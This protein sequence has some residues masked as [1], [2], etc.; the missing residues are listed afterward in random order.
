VIEI[1]KNTNYDFLGRKLLFIGLS[2]FVLL[3]GLASIGWRAL[4]GDQNTH[5]FNFGI[6]FTGGTLVNAKFKEPPD[7]GRLR[8]A[9]EE[10]G[11]DSSKITLQ[12]INEQIGRE[13]KN[14]VFIRI[15]N[16]ETAAGATSNTDLGK[17][18]ILAAL[19]TL[20]D[21]VATQGKINLNLIGRDE[22]K[23][24]FSRLDPLGIR[25]SDRSLPDDSSYG[26]IAVRI[27][28]YREQRGG[29]IGSLDEIKN[30]GGIES[31]L[32]S[33]LEQHFF[34]GASAVRGAE[35]VSPQVG[36]DLR[37]RAIYV[38]IAACAGML[39]YVALRFKSWGYG[40]GAVV[41]VIHDVLVT[42]GI[43][44]IV[45]WEIDLNMI[46]AMLTL[47]GFSMNDTIVIF[48]R[49]RELRRTRRHEYLENITQKAINETLS[50]TVI[51]NGT[52][53][54]AILSL[55][56]FGGEV[57]K[58]FSW[59]LL[60]GV[61]VG[62][63]STLYIASPFMLWWEGGEVKPRSVLASDTQAATVS[64]AMDVQGA[65][66]PT[67]NTVGKGGRKTGKRRR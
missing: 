2:I 20:D 13:S 23:E 42:L 62:T 1:F 36:A 53:F 39:F 41:A 54:L 15:P 63:Y 35:A 30:L 9:I 46:G 66:R 33:V 57:L 28:D 18:K 56:L 32:R 27:I 55:V 45:Q 4:D 34:T 40:L 47:V 67:A 14:E 48:D 60:I 5:P 65:L 38:T 37:N 31:Q 43:F 16:L 7:L 44:S 21:Q 52:T 24:E 17:M 59:A 22:L 8:A 10:Q 50:R 11:I 58:S 61:L 3:A 49:V 6:D 64:S 51:T 25:A 19:A 26:Q 12:P 29:L